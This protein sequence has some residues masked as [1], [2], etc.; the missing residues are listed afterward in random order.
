MSNMT[1][2]FIDK[3]YDIPNDVITYVNFVDFTKF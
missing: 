1:V 3:D 2:K